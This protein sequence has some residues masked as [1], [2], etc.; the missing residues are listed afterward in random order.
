MEVVYP[1]V[2][3]HR[4]FPTSFLFFAVAKLAGQYRQ[5]AVA[6]YHVEHPIGQAQGGLDSVWACLRAMTTFADPANRTAIQGELALA[7]VAYAQNLLSPPRQPLRNTITQAVIHPLYD[8]EQVGWWWNQRMVEFPSISTCLVLSI[9]ST[10]HAANFATTAAPLGLEFNDN[11]VEYGMAVLDISDLDCI[12]YGIVGFTDEEPISAR[13]YVEK[14]ALDFNQVRRH[15]KWPHEG[16]DLDGLQ[17][18]K[19]PL[20]GLDVLEGNTPILLVGS[21]RSSLLTSCDLCSGVAT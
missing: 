1:V 13:S 12:R 7:E 3:D 17:L 5:L 6:R 9:S 20:V 16:R 4:R 2:A 18:D 14:Y 15:L 8:R 21:S 19:Y 11:A 10:G